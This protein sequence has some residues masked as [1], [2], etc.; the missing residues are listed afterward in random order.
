MPSFPDR[1][2][3]LRRQKLISQKL[4]AETIGLSERGI[5]N[6]ERGTNKPTSDILVKLADFFGVTVDY[7][8]GRTNYSVDSDG[9]IAVKAPVDY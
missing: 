8:V 7:L 4:L 9:R 6:Y 1:L 2:K 5:Q 3:E